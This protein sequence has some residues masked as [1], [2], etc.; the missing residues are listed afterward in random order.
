MAFRRPAYVETKTVPSSTT[1][2]TILEWWS[3]SEEALAA[4][5]AVR[6]NSVCIIQLGGASSI[7]V[8][9]PDSCSTSGVSASVQ[10]TSKPRGVVGTATLL[11][12][13]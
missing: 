10:T 7:V 11:M 1:Y 3:T 6:Q 5:D 8:C 2:E 9:V 12:Y 4:R 13:N